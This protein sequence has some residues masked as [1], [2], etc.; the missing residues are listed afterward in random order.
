M[1]KRPHCSENNKTN[2]TSFKIKK[3]HELFSKKMNNVQN[4]DQNKN[5]SQKIS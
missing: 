1:M 5:K 3:K 2:V 4:V